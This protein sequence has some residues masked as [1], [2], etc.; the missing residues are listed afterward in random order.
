MVSLYFAQVVI[1]TADAGFI[2]SIKSALGLGTSSATSSVIKSNNAGTNLPNYFRIEAEIVRME[3]VG[4][5]KSNGG[6]CD[7]LGHCDPVVYAYVD[8]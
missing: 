5:L 6:S 4:G 8:V 1:S 3:N 2:D 7:T